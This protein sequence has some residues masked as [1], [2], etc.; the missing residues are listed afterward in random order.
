MNA[1][2]ERRIERLERIME[3]YDD[4]LLQ[5]TKSFAV[6]DARITGLENHQI[7]QNGHLRRIEDKLNESCQWLNRWIYGIAVGIIMLLL[8][9]W[10][11]G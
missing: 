2:I 4:R 9:L 3:M 7:Q 5:G 11:G 8:T 10:L 6:H 1:D